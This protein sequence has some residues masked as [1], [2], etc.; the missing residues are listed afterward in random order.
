MPFAPAELDDMMVWE[1]T[2]ISIADRAVTMK[3][4]LDRANDAKML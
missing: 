4:I 2:F 3:I 1:W